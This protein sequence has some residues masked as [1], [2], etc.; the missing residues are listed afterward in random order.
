MRRGVPV[1]LAMCTAIGAAPAIADAA[2][3]RYVVVQCQ[4]QNV[5]SPDAV[6][7][8]PRPYGI[9]KGCSMPDRHNA[10]SITNRLNAGNGKAGT[11]RWIAPEHTAFTRV[12]LEAKLR[13]KKGHYSRIYMADRDGRQTRRIASGD[14]SPGGFQVEKWAGAREE[15]LVAALGCNQAGGCPQSNL[16]QTHVREVRMTLADLAD[17]T[18]EVSGSLVSG[19]WK[20]GERLLEHSANDNGTGMASLL[21]R[22]NGLDVSR[23]DGNCPGVVDGTH[24]ATRLSP[25]SSIIHGTAVALTTDRD[26]FVDGQNSV[27]VCA[28]DYAGNEGCVTSQVNVDNADPVLAFTNAQDPDDPELIRALVTDAHSGVESGQ[29]QY[30]AEGATLWQPLPTSYVSGE[31]RARV[32]STSVPPG[33]YEFRAVATDHASNQGETTHREDGFEMKL[34]FPLKSGVIL[35]AGL[36]PGGAKRMTVRYGRR[37]RVEGRLRN[38][39]GEPLPGQEIVV[40]EYFGEGALIRERISRVLTD[41]FGRWSSRLPAGPSRRVT[42]TY[43]GNQRYLAESTL[44]GRLAVRTKASLRASR[45]RVPEGGKVVFRGRLGR[46]GARIPAGGKLLEL[47]VKQTRNGYQTVGQG[48]RSR[49]NGRFRIKYR[50][51]RF[52]QYDVKFRFRLKVARES[53]WP[54]KAPVR[55]R[56]RVVKVL[57]R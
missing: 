6:L 32:D 3:A 5:P 10:I 18:V 4:P 33:P 54:Y 53:N 28:L 52:Y 45:R 15:Q 48:F 42:A 35:N 40:V 31:L 50:F 12:R 19:G 26:P 27:A 36:E 9:A 1:M 57:A 16:A 25:C 2:G 13:R 49:P 51:G 41:E 8:E 30:R 47:Q 23:R 24:L 29:I 46:L 17:P 44:G 39:A 20:R 11:V 14:S 55:S 34:H 7:K 22:V 43:E 37:S 38:A 21:I 56:K